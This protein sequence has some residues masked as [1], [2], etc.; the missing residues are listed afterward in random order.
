M[1]SIPTKIGGSDGGKS[2]WIELH[3]YLGGWPNLAGDS[4]DGLWSD[5]VIFCKNQSKLIKFAIWI[6]MLLV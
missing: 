3:L 1:T 6:L 4:R 5:I 2:S